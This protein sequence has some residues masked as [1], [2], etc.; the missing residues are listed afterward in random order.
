MVWKLLEYTSR[1]ASNLVAILV[2]RV[3]VLYRRHDLCTARKVKA[4][5]YL[6]SNSQ[7]V[8]FLDVLRDS[9]PYQRPGDNQPVPIVDID[10]TA[11]QRQN[12]DVEGSNLL[13]GHQ[14]Q[15][16]ISNS[17]DMIFEDSVAFEVEGLQ[18]EA[19]AMLNP[20]WTVR[21]DNF[22]ALQSTQPSVG[23]D[24]FHTETLEPMLQ[25][26]YID[27]GHQSSGVQHAGYA[28]LPS[29]APQYNHMGGNI[30]TPLR[31]ITLPL[32]AQS[33]A[34]QQLETAND[35]SMSDFTESVYSIPMPKRASKRTRIKAS[36]SRKKPC[37]TPSHLTQNKDSSAL[38]NNLPSKPTTH[39]EAAKTITTNN[40]ISSEQLTHGYARAS[41]RLDSMPPHEQGSDGRKKFDNAGIVRDIKI[42]D[43]ERRPMSWPHRNPWRKSLDI[44][45]AVLTK[46][47][48]KLM[49]ERGEAASSVV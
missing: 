13:F 14:S 6:C 9:A 48:E 28:Y 32:Q 33:N 2:P 46:G 7:H 15:N 31:N 22:A 36:L 34:I 27:L 10:D 24:H 23:M 29:T 8:S 43:S 25:N 40:I 19:N 49:T 5:T 21:L 11:G 12:V 30:L 1:P 42:L 35:S 16:S 45:V 39:T 18:A 41:S 20:E 38:K 47:F 44:S 4:L 17:Q 37:L 26:Q 3:S